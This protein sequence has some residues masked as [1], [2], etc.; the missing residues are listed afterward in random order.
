[1]PSFLIL[2]GRGIA[3]TLLCMNM[4]YCWLVGILDTTE[5]LNEF[6]YVVAFLQILILKSPCLKPIVLALT[7]ALSQRTQILIYTA[8][9]LGYRH[10]VVVY[11]DDD[12]RAKL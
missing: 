12:A 11:N 5:H 10:L 8:M 4:Y 7:T 9:V 1:M 6:F 3:M 2:Y